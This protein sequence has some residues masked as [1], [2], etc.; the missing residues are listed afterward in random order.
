MHASSLIF[1][2]FH[3]GCYATSAESTSVIEKELLFLYLSSQCHLSL[4]I[5]SLLASIALQFDLIL[6][7]CVTSPVLD[8]PSVP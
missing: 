2:L 6:P 1:F 5:N 8:T 4:S 3:F 7:S